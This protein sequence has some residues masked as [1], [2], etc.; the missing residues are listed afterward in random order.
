MAASVKITGSSKA[1]VAVGSRPDFKQRGAVTYTRPLLSR[2]YG[3]GILAD[4]QGNVGMNISPGIAIQSLLVYDGGD[5]V[6]T[7]TPT[8]LQGASWD[9]VATANPRSGTFHVEAA[10]TNNNDLASFADGTNTYNLNDYVLFEAFIKINSWPTQGNKEVFVQ[11]YDNGTQVSN[12]IGISGYI[13]TANTA[14][15]Q[16][17]QVPLSA[18]TFTASSFDEIRLRIVDTG[19][20][21]A[22]QFDL[23][24][25]N[26]VEPGQTGTVEYTFA[27]EPDEVFELRKLEI[28]AVADSDK[29]KYDKFFSLNQLANGLLVTW[30]VNGQVAA[31]LVATRDYDWALSA[32]ARLEIIR[33]VGDVDG[34]YRVGIEI[35]PEL[36]QLRGSTNDKITITVRDDLSTLREMN[37]TVNGAY[38]LN[39]FE[40]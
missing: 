32:G 5:T 30:T 28:I 17:L 18:F 36:I 3:A 31:N 10:N 8:A 21:Q 7:F 9:F 34:I 23:D 38:I 2:R 22:P 12:E 16:L 27:P 39:E 19:P 29:I 1:S 26:M 14:T 6:S 33:T 35:D 15:Y 37:A 13:N 25:I 20:G 24:D 4:A 40:E 11:F